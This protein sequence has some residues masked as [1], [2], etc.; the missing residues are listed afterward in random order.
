MKYDVII[1]GGGASGLTAAAYLSRAGRTVLLLEKEDQ[2][3]G[4]VNSFNRD[5]FIFD[6]GLRAFDSAGV[7]LPMLD[8]LGLEMDLV[9]NIISIGIE[10]RVIRVESDQNLAEYEQLLQQLYPESRAEVSA[11]IADM[12]KM[13]H[14]LDIQYGI[15]NPLFLDFRED[16]DYFLKKVFPWMFRFALT[17]PRIAAR[18]QP[19]E[20]YLRQFT[21][22]QKLID[23][24]AQHFFTATPAYFALSYFSLYQ[25]YYYPKGGTGVF[26]EALTQL[27]QDQ[28]GQM[29]THARVNA[30]QPER[31]T[32][33][34]AGGEAYAYDQLL[35]AADQKTLYR[36]VDINSL[37]NPRLASKVEEKR[38]QLADLVGND[39]IFTLYVCSD[40]PGEFFEEVSSGHF[41]YTPSREGQSQA[42]PI[43]RN[44]SWEEIQQWLERFF[45]LTTYEISIPALRDPSLA[46][47]GKTGLIISVLFDYALTKHID[48]HGW[49]PAFRTLASELILNTLSGSIYPGLGDSV[50]DH[51]S[52]TP[53]TMEKR[54]GSTDGAIT[55]WAFTNDLMPAESR[56]VKIAN[57][58]NTPLPDISQA[59]QWTY[60]PSGFP[61][62]LI[63]G[64]L[65]ADKIDSRLKRRRTAP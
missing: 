39:S 3:G 28:G 42:G 1:V 65:A 6:G 41:F 53:L 37:T 34:T 57:A 27:I 19:V 61:V 36:L 48:D 55:G 26:T 31:K 50:L 59:G 30:I 2:F 46:P 32:L 10:N 22:N 5:G 40:L 44:G 21:Q 11:I 51:F 18:N 4:L 29:K 14:F 45:A 25:D 7:L 38:Y 12:R 33:S 49:D 16:R 24:I 43:P 64:K 15:D 20:A 63:T 8:K 62:A 35:W 56:L 13:M 9:K 60:S 23:I 47:K 17:A 58:V 52:A 54:T